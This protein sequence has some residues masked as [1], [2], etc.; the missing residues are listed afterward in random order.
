MRY[1]FS[2]LLL[3]PLAAASQQPL[4]IGAVVSETGVHANLAA[5]Y[6]KALLLWEDEV[7]AAGGLLGRKVE[8]RLRDDGS[9]AVKA[10]AL[11][12]QLIEEK[13]DALIG[14]YGSAA[15]LMAAGEAEG[16]RRVLINGA[17]WSQEVHKRGPRFV[18]QSA[19]PY[20]A[21]GEAIVQFAQQAGS[22]TPFILTRDIPGAREMATAAAAAAL[23]A[24]LTAGE[25]LAYSGGDVMFR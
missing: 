19:T 11:Y 8:L 3:L 22:H 25:V 4:V 13:A 2:F 5:D 9:E 17:G 7:N 18:F 6:R 1:V 21:Y 20:R 15:T 24:G 12:R 23:K 16:G 14:P 10:G